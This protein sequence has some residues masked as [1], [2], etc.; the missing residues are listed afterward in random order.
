MNWYSATLFIFVLLSLTSC[1]SSKS[2][3]P[4]DIG[5][6]NVKKI[7]YL[8]IS[9]SHD[10]SINATNLINYLKGNSIDSERYGDDEILVIF[11]ERKI[12]LTP[13]FNKGEMSRVIIKKYYGIKDE[14]NNSVEIM[15]LLLA[16][17]DRMNFG[18]YATEHEGGYLVIT[19]NHVFVDRLELNPL[20]KHLSYMNDVINY[21][22]EAD[23]NI[24][25][26]I[27]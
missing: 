9:D 11:E 23:L 10:R 26:Y 14:Y 7:D 6:S 25:E 15:K 22:F 27:E 16:L 12:L 4:E 5:S 2:V 17:N 18:Q 20:L 19:S 8:D 21:L 1:A 13:R 3:A 24:K